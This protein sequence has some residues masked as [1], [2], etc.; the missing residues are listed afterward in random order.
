MTGEA[1]SKVK[2]ETKGSINSL[3][4]LRRPIGKVLGLAMLLLTGFALYH[5]MFVSVQY[6]QGWPLTGLRVPASSV[7]AS[8]PPNPNAGGPGYCPVGYVPY[9]GNMSDQ[10]EH[11]QVF[12]SNRMN[13]EDNWKYIDRQLSARSGDIFKSSPKH[14]QQSAYWTLDDGK[15]RVFLTG[16]SSGNQQL[17]CLEIVSEHKR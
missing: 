7:R 15:K 1:D 8:W 16:M 6:P 2:S 4:L 12:Y 17:C 10:G 3:S 14:S 5:A 9:N 13:W 11:L